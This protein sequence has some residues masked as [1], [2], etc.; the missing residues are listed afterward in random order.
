LSVARFRWVLPLLLV[1]P[2][3]ARQPHGA[4]IGEVGLSRSD[5][6]IDAVV[7]G[8]PVRLAVTLDE[9]V[10]LSRALADRLPVAWQPG[11]KEY[12]GRVLIKHREAAGEVTVSGTTAPM[13]LQTQDAPCC[14]AHEGAIGVTELPWPTV[15]IGTAGADG[16]RL[17]PSTRAAESGLSI[18]WRVGHDTIHVVLSLD[19]PETVA[20]AS[21]AAILSKAY[22]GRLGNEVRQLPVAYGISRSVRDMALGQP[23]SLIGFPL[24]RIAVRIG[25][26]AGDTV[27]PQPDLPRAENTGEIVVSHRP[28]PQFRWAAI[29]VGR[30]LLDRCAQI[31]VYRDKKQIGLVCRL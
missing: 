10:N 17:Y 6:A 31:S 19:T 29:T 12:V 28:P 8:V 11:S 13:T 1:T 7:A 9:G 21:A 3:T 15:R 18:P 5:P 23:A 30:D 26:Y 25:D 2:A 20:T 27:L 4:D 16:E 24:T 22:G 14:G